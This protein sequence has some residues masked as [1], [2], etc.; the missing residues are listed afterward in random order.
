MPSGA[1]LVTLPGTAVVALIRA[2]G[3]LSQCGL[4]R[5]ANVG[6]VAVTARLGTAHRESHVAELP[7]D[8]LTADDQDVGVSRDLAGRPQ[9]VGQLRPLHGFLCPS[10]TV[11][12]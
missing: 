7:E 5:Y 2:V 10:V 8:R 1:D 11:R 4:K 9:D 3:A 6:G 12:S